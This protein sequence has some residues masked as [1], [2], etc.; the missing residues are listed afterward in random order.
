[1]PNRNQKSQNLQ[2]SYP[3]TQHPVHQSHPINQPKKNH[4]PLLQTS[5]HQQIK[6]ARSQHHQ[7]PQQ[8]HLPHQSMPRPNQ[9][10]K[11]P[12]RHHHHAHHEKHRQKSLWN[13]PNRPTQK[14]LGQPPLPRS[15]HHL[16]PQPRTQVAHTDRSRNRLSRDHITLSG[17]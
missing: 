2:T 7:A 6:S 13:S 10:S 8:Q 1:M 16:P 9:H 15:K 4:L 5:N 14:H 3:S 12:A 17:T 11:H